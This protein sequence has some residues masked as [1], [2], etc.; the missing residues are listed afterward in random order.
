MV[1]AITTGLEY[2]DGQ[3]VGVRD[4]MESA[5]AGGE[6]RGEALKAMFKHHKKD[7]EE[8]EKEKER[9]REKGSMKS[10]VSQSQFKV[11]ADKRQS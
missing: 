10:G 7:S 3:L 6:G 4:R 1:D 8:E 9:E 5:K 2:V 11:V